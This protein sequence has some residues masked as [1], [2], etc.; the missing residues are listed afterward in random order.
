MIDYNEPLEVKVVKMS[1]GEQEKLYCIC[2]KPYDDS[3]F[4]I[5]CDV[6]EDWFHG[7]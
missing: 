1:D 5:E 3:I 4:M 7:E 6:C 2:R